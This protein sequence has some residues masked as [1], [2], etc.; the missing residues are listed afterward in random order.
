MTP[1][2]SGHPTLDQNFSSLGWIISNNNND[3]NNNNNNI[4]LLNIGGLISYLFH[5]Q[6]FA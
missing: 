5:M 4:C 3:D 2:V 1:A 6:M